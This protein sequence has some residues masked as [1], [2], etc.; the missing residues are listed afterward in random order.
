[1][2]WRGWGEEILL[3]CGKEKEKTVIITTCGQHELTRLKSSCALAGIRLPVEEVSSPVMKHDEMCAQCAKRQC[4]SSERRNQTNFT[5]TSPAASSQRSVFLGR[6]KLR[7]GTEQTAALSK[8]L[9]L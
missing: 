6:V 3:K 5:T 7:Q 1:M 9:N 8:S 4:P 2:G